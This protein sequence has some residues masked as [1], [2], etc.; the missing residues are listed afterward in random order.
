MASFGVCV[1]VCVVCITEFHPSQVEGAI[2]SAVKAVDEDNRRTI[3]NIESVA[4]NEARLEAKIDKKK[5]ELERNQ[6][7]LNT[8]KKVRP[9]FMDEYEKL[10]E[11]LK[12]VYEVTNSHYF[13]L[14]KISRHSSDQQC[15]CR[16]PN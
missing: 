15:L 16:I 1:C 9:A 4:S 6:K 10:E 13:L 14:S 2:R 8:L 12:A 3:H 11:E 7:R 5:V